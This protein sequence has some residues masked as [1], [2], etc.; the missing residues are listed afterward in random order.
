[1]GLLGLSRWY[2]S[3]KLVP[4]ASHN[5]DLESDFLYALQ[6]A[7]PARASFC[8]PLDVCLAVTDEDAPCRQL[9][10]S[11][12]ASN[13]TGAGGSQADPGFAWYQAQ[14]P[15]IE[16]HHQTKNAKERAAKQRAERSAARHTTTNASAPIDVLVASVD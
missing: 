7:T 12:R 4:H 8:P 11:A 15:P 16:L 1:M 6:L 13:A 5:F 9:E 14:K 3:Y 2:D 10:S